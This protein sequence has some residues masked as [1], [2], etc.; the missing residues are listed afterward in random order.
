MSVK[1]MKTMKIATMVVLTTALILSAVPQSSFAQNT[2]SERKALEKEVSQKTNELRRANWTMAGSRT[3]QAA[4]TNH[5]QQLQQ[6]ENMI[7][8]IGAS[9]CQSTGTN[10]CRRTASSNAR[11]EFAARSSAEVQGFATTLMH[12]IPDFNLQFDQTIETTE[13]LIQARIGN[14]MRESFSVVKQNG[15]GSQQME[16]Y[17][18]VNVNDAEEII[19]TA[20]KESMETNRISIEAQREI[21]NAVRERF[22]LK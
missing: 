21:S 5:Y 2:R 15:D 22:S 19:R 8:I 20:L 16:T 13:Q 3:M 14:A 1:K 4:L 12:N 6:T 7:E 9:R 10:V 11:I 18:L 17:F